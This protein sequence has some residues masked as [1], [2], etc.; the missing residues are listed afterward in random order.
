M[1]Q[2]LNVVR[3]ANKRTCVK[4]DILRKC[5]WVFFS[6]H[7]WSDIPSVWLTSSMEQAELYTIH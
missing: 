3:H 1:L 5:E 4:A 6:E 2:Q 7:S